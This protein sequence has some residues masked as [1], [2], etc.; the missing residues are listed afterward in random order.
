[1]YIQFVAFPEYAVQVIHN[2]NPLKRILP[3][4]SR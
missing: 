1:M 2:D 3:G 4:D